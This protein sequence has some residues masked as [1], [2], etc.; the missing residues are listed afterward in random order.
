MTEKPAWIKTEFVY[1]P[2]PI[3]NMDWSAIDDRHYGGDPSDSIGR[4][5]I[6]Q[7]SIDDLMD[8][9]C[10]ARGADVDNNNGCRACS[11]EVGYCLPPSTNKVK[12]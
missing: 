12:S 3:R 10:M 5:E 2:I 8:Q 6:E 11:A 1:P 7:E 9:I 4:G